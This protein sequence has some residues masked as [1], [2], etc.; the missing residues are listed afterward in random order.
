MT[1]T[2]P[3]CTA[4]WIMA[5]SDS[6]FMGFNSPSGLSGSPSLSSSVGGMS[7]HSS[8]IYGLPPTEADLADRNA[9]FMKNISSGGYSGGS[10][11]LRSGISSRDPF[12][13][14][15]FDSPS[16]GG[17]P[18]LDS[19]IEKIDFSSLGKPKEDSPSLD[20][21]AFSY[22]PF[23]IPRFDSPPDFG[24]SSSLRS[25][26]GKSSSQNKNSLTVLDFPSSGFQVHIHEGAG[27]S[28][29]VQ[30]YGGIGPKINVSSYDV[31][32]LDY[33]FSKLFPK[34]KSST[35]VNFHNLGRV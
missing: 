20:S 11:S 33:D 34:S 21:S 13:F 6:R 9:Q 12:V 1:A 24:G 28:A 3:S 16:G 30:P 4:P 19:R 23:T 17:S 25:G 8:S 35:P 2:L 27:G 18:S 5:E 26:I 32:T 15:K 29:N 10:S 22:K 7:S 14:P 31:A